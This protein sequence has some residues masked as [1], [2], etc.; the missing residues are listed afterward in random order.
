MHNYPH[1][2]II[3]HEFV[4]NPEAE[5]IIK[6]AAPTI[7]PAVVGKMLYIFINFMNAAHSL[8]CDLDF[9]YS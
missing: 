9:P 6:V 5:S 2:V 7:Q 3:F 4:S 1:K 8:P